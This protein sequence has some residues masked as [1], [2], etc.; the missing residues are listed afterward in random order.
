MKKIFVVLITFCTVTLSFNGKLNTNVSANATVQPKAKLAIVIDDFGE[1]RHGVEEMLNVKAPLTVAVIPECEYSKA[2]AEQ[3]HQK[4]HE[5]ILHMPMENQTAMPASYY[6]PVLIKNSFSEQE[7]VETLSGCIEKTPY[8]KGVNIHMGTGVSRN[9]TLIT[10]MMQEVKRRDLY[11]LDSKTVEDSVCP[12]CANETGVK[13]FVRD[14]FLEPSGRPNYQ[15]AVNGIMQA[16]ELALNQGRAV[17]IGH[18]GP[19]GLAE[20]ARAISDCLPK[21]ESMGVEVVWL[22]KL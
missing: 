14:V 13:F 3:A 22:S 18:V 8:C 10:A 1:D 6:G 5:V 11:F 15:I 9:K 7:A 17:A 12:R 4:G 2:D 19:V 20:T 16:G 21:L